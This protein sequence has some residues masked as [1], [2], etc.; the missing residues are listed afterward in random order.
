MNNVVPANMK[1]VATKTRPKLDDL[2]PDGWARFLRAVDRALKT[3]PIH[4]KAKPT[5]PARPQKKPRGTPTLCSH[6][7]Y[8]RSWLRSG[9]GW[10][11]PRGS[12]P[13]CRT[14]WV[15]PCLHPVRP[16]L[17][18]PQRRLL[19]REALLA[20]SCVGPSTTS[21]ARRRAVRVAPRHRS[22]RAGAI[23]G[24]GCVIPVKSRINVARTSGQ[25]EPEHR[26]V[27]TG[28]SRKKPPTRPPMEPR[29]IRLYR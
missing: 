27:M 20:L 2:R 8:V 26:L 18:G 17:H 15:V 11:E 24:P 3:P 5:A 9:R 7:R 21:P 13:M 29:E 16:D 25:N 14:R 19:R 10:R 23:R 22:G 28:F 4:R 6:D 1:A 12:E